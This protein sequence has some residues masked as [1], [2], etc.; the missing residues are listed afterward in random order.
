MIMSASSKLSNGVLS[1]QSPPQE[2]AEALGQSELF[3]EFQEK[4]SKVAPVNR[5]VLLFGERGTGKE[6]AASRL[7]YLSNRWKDPFIT[8]NCSALSPTLI[9][10]ELFGH[11]R[12]AFTSASRQRTGR[13]EMAD[14]GSFFLDEI[15]NIPMEAQEKI[16][17]VVEYGS[18]E[19]VGSS[20]PIHVDVR[21]IA[22]T[23]VD[24]SIKAE[25]GQFMRDLLDRLSF[26]VL[27]LPPL[28]KRQ[29]DIPLLAE[30]FAAR[31]AFEVGRDLIPRFSQRAL[32]TLEAYHWPGNIRELKNVVERAV[33]RSESPA[34]DSIVFNPFENPYATVSSAQKPAP[35][36]TF[37]ADPSRAPFEGDIYDTPLDDAVWTLKVRLL[38]NA[39]VRANF[40]QKKAA[41]ILGITYHQFRGLYRKYR[42][43][44]SV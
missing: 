8:L 41:Q 39:L 4:L 2:L 43:K 5:P 29:G 28:R 22:A 31:M 9:T 30:H 17:R 35:E 27:Y 12:G 18:F 24:L 16:L 11:E 3:L 32:S 7:H 44:Q 26:E 15:G 13:F 1:A 20:N 25:N 42:K 10:S 21:I 34:I 23:N 36:K 14:Q 19:R 38:E 37:T 40:K 33:Y 6:L